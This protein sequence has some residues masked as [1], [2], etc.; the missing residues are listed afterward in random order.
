MLKL[1]IYCIFIPEASEISGMRKF[2][3]GRFIPVPEKN[4]KP[5]HHNIFKTLAQVSHIGFRI[6]ACVLF[7]DL[8]GRYLDRV[9][10]TTRGLLLT[11]ALL[12]AGAAIKQIFDG[13]KTG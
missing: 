1:R 5:H 13:I 3:E 8:L 7:G 11:F 6:A 10:G 12:G 9:F 2:V 4:A